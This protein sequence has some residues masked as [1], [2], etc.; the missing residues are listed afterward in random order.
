VATAGHSAVKPTEV[1]G[2][3]LAVRHL[4]KEGAD[5]IKVMATGGGTR[6]TFPYRASYSPAELRAAADEAHA[7]GRL[8][9][10]HATGA[11]VGVA[12]VFDLMCPWL[13]LRDMPIRQVRLGGAAIREV[14]AGLTAF[15]KIEGL[16]RM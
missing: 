12:Y 14:D 4:A 5:W 15:H 8:L 7:G 16:R 10:V 2:G 9:G 13:V 11:D 6:N 3:R 1:D